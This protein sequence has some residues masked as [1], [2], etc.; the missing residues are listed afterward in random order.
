MRTIPLAA[1]I[2]TLGAA[3]L[4]GPVLAQA[5]DSSTPM[6]SASTDATPLPSVVT[7][8]SPEVE[9]TFDQ[10]R[11]RKLSLANGPSGR[12]DHTWTVDREGRYAYLFGGRDGQ[13][14]RGDLWR[15]DL[16]SDAWK[17][18]APDGASPEPRFGHSAVWADGHGLIVF[19]GQ[20]GAAFFDD[21]WRYDPETGRWAELPRRGAAPMARYGSC[22]IVGPDERLWISHGFTFAG[23]FD[24][25]RAYD[26]DS[27]RWSSVGPVGRRPGERCL[28]DCFTTSN[29]ELVLFGGQD[30]GAFALGDL[31]AMRGDRTWERLPDPDLAPRRLYAVTEAGADAYLFGG[32]DEE[33]GD[34]AD[35]WRIDRELLVFEPVPVPGPSPSARHAASI[36]TD[37]EG[38]R[39]LL[40]G[41]QGRVAK[42]D[43]WELVDLAD[44]PE[45]MPM[46][47]PSPSAAP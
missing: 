6:P 16:R 29:G 30:D 24:D 4:A 17:R 20:R 38:G 36:I 44:A 34:L 37:L 10:P 22:M 23:R 1:L 40:F 11:W 21:L 26:L 7:A 43:L 12:E 32:A 13:R 42:A 2:M 18:L 27:E 35:L 19:G 46:T 25:T 31:W 15:Y 3:L 45:P 28:H 39:L 5:D 33:G 47:E 14:E 8:Q 9:V 41:G